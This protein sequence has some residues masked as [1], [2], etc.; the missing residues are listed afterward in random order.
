MRDHD[1]VPYIVIERSGSGMAPFVWGALMG[2]AAALLFAPKTGA[3]TQRDLKERATK[4]RELAEEKVGELQDSF[5]DAL[6]QG[7]EQVGKKFETAKRSVEEG[8]SKAQ[9]AID[10]GKKAAKAARTEF[11]DRVGGDDGDESSA[12]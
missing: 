9:Q 5:Q 11:E 8:R 12:S 1:D 7:R 10:A 6:D 2:A 4:L 3:E